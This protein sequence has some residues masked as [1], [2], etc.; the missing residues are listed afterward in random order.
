MIESE[1]KDLEREIDY[2][3]IECFIIVLYLVKE[4]G[5]FINLGLTI[6]IIYY[7]F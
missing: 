4:I 7:S 6:I 3:E 5:L 2:L 1:L